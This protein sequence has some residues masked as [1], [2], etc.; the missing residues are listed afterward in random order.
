MQWTTGGKGVGS[1]GVSLIFRFTLTC[2]VQMTAAAV[3]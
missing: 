3:F 2:S 1:E